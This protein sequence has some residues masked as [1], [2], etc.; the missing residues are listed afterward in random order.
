MFNWVTV[1]YYY[2]LYILVNIVAHKQTNWTK[3]DTGPVPLGI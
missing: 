3:Q 2:L 1:I